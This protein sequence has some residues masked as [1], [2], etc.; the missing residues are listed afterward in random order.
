M[1]AVSPVP[2]LGL[3]LHDVARGVRQ[4]FDMRA[5]SLGVTRQQW[6]TLIAIARAEGASQAELA[7]RLEV[8][9]ITLCRMID[10]LADAG[11][12]ERRADPRDRRIWRVHLRPDARTLVE[13]LR[14]VAVGVEEEILADFPAEERA[15]L[16]AGLNRLRDALRQD[17]ST[18]AA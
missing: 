4:R 18:Q 1:L 7:E 12:V 5:R 9:R 15:S 8:E 14:E 2:T 17:R 16:V 10:R 13:R 11:L 6:R 3:L